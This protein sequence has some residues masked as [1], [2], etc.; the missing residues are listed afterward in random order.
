MGLDPIFS[1]VLNPK[2]MNLPLNFPNPTLSLPQHHRVFWGK[3]LALCL[4]VMLLAIATLVPPAQAA[5]LSPQPPAALGIFKQ[6]FAGTAPDDLGVNQGRLKA[7]PPSPNCVSSQ[8]SDPDHAIAPLTYNQETTTAKALLVEVLG[9]VPG[10]VI[11]EETA[12][13]IRAESSSKLLG[14]VDDVEFFFPSDR[15]VIE[16]RSASRLG[17]S[18]L[19]VNRRRLEQIRFA[20]ADLGI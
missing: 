9:V 5:P 2:P 11:V 8:V 3:T 13:Y 10:T 15:P 12:D 19:G 18:D 16:M 4:A 6:V 7:C 1:L 14:F 17:Q 20:L